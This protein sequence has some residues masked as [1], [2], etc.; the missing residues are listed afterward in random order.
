M[1]AVVFVG[2]GVGMLLPKVAKGL[3]TCENVFFVGGMIVLFLLPITL[4]VRSYLYDV[5]IE[6]IKGGG[7]KFVSRHVRFLSRIW[8][9]NEK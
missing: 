7:L 5:F 1:I 2:I 4:I 9:L 8:T 6:D 3:E